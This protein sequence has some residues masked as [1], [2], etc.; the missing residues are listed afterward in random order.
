[1]QGFPTLKVFRN[2]GGQ[3]GEYDAARKSAAIVK[4][5]A[6]QSSPSVNELA[7]TDA[8]KD[9]AKDEHVKVVAFVKDGDNLGAFTKAANSMRN[10]YFFGVVKNNDAA[11]AEFKVTSTPTFVLFRD[12]DEGHVVY[13]GDFSSQQDIVSYIRGQSFPLVGVIGPENYAKYLERGFN[14]VWLF[15]DVES[16]D[17]KQLITETITPVAAAHRTALSFVQLDG[18]KW[19]EHAKSFGLSGNLPAIVLEDREGRKNFIFPEDQVIT[20]KAFGDF[21]SGVLAGTVAASVKSEAEPETNDGPVFVL[22]GTNFDRVVMDNTKDVLV[23]FYAP[24]CG[25][26][27][28]L[29]PKYDELGMMFKNDA[30]AVIAKVDATANDTPADVQ[31]FPTIILYPAGDKSKPINFEGER[32]VKAMAAFFKANGKAGGRPEAAAVA[33]AAAGHDHDHDHDEHDHDHG[34]HDHDHG[35]H[36]HVHEEL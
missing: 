5:M 20:E 19:V 7:D 26:C 18:V 6:R 16:A 3:P 22:V 29:A 30:T 1:M 27:K 28:S 2:D 36:D 10:D 33:A 14:F 13:P 25:H 32:N 23:E 31:G 17:H 4:F 24:W 12:F 9:F 11:N 34:D 15:V 8:V 21:I 35:D